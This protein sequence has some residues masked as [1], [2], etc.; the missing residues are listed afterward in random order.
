[1]NNYSHVLITTDF[2]EPSRRAARKGLA[3]AQA[4]GAGLSLLHVIEHF[5]SDMPAAWVAPEDVD[6][7]V[8]YQARAAE[9]LARLAEELGCRDAAQEVIVTASSAGHAIADFAKQ[10]Q[11][12][13][14]VAGIQGGWVI[15][16]LGS[17]AMAIV[18]Q[19]PCDVLL[20]R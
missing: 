12:D 10:E 8:Y 3:E 6:P 2:S 11:V 4:H 16:M 1:M 13:L 17:T 18:R 20:V 9:E 15:G 5:P 14:I 7:A 19:A